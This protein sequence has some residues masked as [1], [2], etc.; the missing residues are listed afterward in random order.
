[1][2][3]I[4]LTDTGE[5]LIIPEGSDLT[6][7]SPLSADGELGCHKWGDCNG[8]IHCSA[9]ATGWTV[10]CDCCGWRND[11]VPKEVKT[12]GDLRRFFAEEHAKKH[13]KK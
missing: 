3:P 10:I 6:E 13:A 7:E 4:K 8:V 12:C 5:M 11:D 9:T 2:E 1:M